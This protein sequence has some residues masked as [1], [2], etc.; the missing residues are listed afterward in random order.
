MKVNKFLLT[1]A[2]LLVAAFGLLM[3]TSPNAQPVAATSTDAYAISQVAAGST[4][5]TTAGGNLTGWDSAD[6]GSAVVQV[7]ADASATTSTLTVYPQ[8]SNEI[9]VPCASVTNWFTGV[10]YIAYSSPAQYQVVRADLIS[11]TV[12]ST[13][14][15]PLTGVAQI[16]SYTVDSTDSLPF[17]GVGQIISYTVYST[18]SLAWTSTGSTTLTG[19]VPYAVTS[20]YTYADASPTLTGSVPYGITSTYTYADASPVITGNIPYV[21]TTTYTYATPSIVTYTL[22]AATAGYIAVDQSLA[23]TGDAY[24]GKESTV[25]G[26]CMRL[27][28]GVSYG[29][30]TPTINVMMRDSNR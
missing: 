26:R 30:I 1:I 2:L 6:Y 17:T 3:L 10:D 11:Y 19:S 16:I 20:T 13:D 15:L 7:I 21:V 5:Y 22:A 27:S 23:L 25:Y 9:N 12:N 28:L 29:T 24:G 4:V 14:S 18:D 8:F